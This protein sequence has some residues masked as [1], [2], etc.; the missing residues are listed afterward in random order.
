MH[1]RRLLLEQQGWK[2]CFG[3]IKSRTVNSIVGYACWHHNQDAVTLQ[4]VSGSG[5]VEQ[6][7]QA[8]QHCPTLCQFNPPRNSFIGFEFKLSNVDSNDLSVVV[9]G[10]NQELVHEF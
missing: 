2:W 3:A 7:I 5:K 10:S 6:E 8:K 9:K 1:S 4:L